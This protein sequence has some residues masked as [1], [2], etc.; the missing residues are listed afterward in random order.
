MPPKRTPSQCSIEEDGKRCEKTAH[1]RGWCDMHYARWRLKGSPYIRD[2]LN[3]KPR[4]NPPID[5]E[6]RFWAKVQKTDTCWLWI[7]SL[8]RHG[9]GQFRPVGGGTIRAHHFLIGKP[10][11]GLD[12]D[13]LC[14]ARNCV[15]P[16]HLELVTRSENLM[17]GVLYRRAHPLVP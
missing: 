4:G 6:L 17:R 8:D 11:K 14:R 10:P 13:H 7:A 15:R 5:A 2:V 3:P 12:W 16:E 9:Y 1:R